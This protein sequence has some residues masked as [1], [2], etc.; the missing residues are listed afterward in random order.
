MFQF[1]Q[2]HSI[3]EKILDIEPNYPQPN[4]PQP[5]YPQP[6]YP[7]PNYPQPNY[8][9]PNYPQPNYPQPNYPQPNYPQPNYLQPALKCQGFVDD[10]SFPMILKESKFML[11][12]ENTSVVKRKDFVTAFALF[13]CSHCMFNLSYSRNLV[14][15]MAFFQKCIIKL[16]EDT[17]KPAKILGSIS[18]IRKTELFSFEL[19]FLFI[20]FRVRATFFPVRSL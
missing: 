11:T 15:S 1:W 10:N 3:C 14:S 20:F 8:P 17:A 4:Y 6:D 7:Q 19:L 13:L 9:Q 5:N 16:P 2:C 12:I 18:E